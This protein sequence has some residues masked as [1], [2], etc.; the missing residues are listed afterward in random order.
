MPTRDQFPQ[1]R[2]FHGRHDENNAFQTGLKLEKTGLKFEYNG[3]GFPPVW[4]TKI[5]KVDPL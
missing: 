5:Q 2:D 1:S 3:T 4:L